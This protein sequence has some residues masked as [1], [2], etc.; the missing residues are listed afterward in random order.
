MDDD[1]TRI[2]LRNRSREIV[3]YALIDTADAELV[4][5]QGSWHVHEGYAS[6]GIA[7]PPRRVLHIK[8][9]RL[10]LGLERGDP[11]QGDHINRD[12][13]DNR[14]ENLRIV[15]PTINAQNATPRR[16]TSS[17][18]RGVSWHNGLQM[19]RARV[20]IDGHMHFLGWYDDE[21]E[22]ARIARNFR[23]AHM[24]GATD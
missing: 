18:H 15:T 24:P 1:V 17:T 20:R 23:L 11:R 2:P 21:L 22:A 8:M 13:L 4:T 19:W 7:V 9:H 10:I 16:N 5:N 12:R 3:A 6:H 14:R